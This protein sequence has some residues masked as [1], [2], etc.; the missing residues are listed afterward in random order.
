MVAVAVV[1]V[2]ELVHR[3]THSDSLA[4]ASFRMIVLADQHLP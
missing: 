4:L 3:I 1:V 2:V